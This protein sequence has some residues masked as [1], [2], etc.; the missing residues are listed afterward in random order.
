MLY[1][2]V[3][4]FVSYAPPWIHGDA[5]LSPKE[6]A[7]GLRILLAEHSPRFRVF[8]VFRGLNAF[9]LFAARHSPY[10]LGTLRFASGTQDLS[11]CA[12]SCVV[13]RLCFGLPGS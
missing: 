2:K 4:L 9:T 11:A 12:N 10:S 3:F 8:R 13:S 6:M 1:A 7:R 5:S